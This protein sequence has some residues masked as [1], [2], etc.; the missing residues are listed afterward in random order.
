MVDRDPFLLETN[1]P[2]IFAA[3]DVHRGSVKRL[4]L[5]PF[6]ISHFLEFV[7]HSNLLQNLQFGQYIV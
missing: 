5:L 4:F 2:V 7:L 1:I 3:G 6:M